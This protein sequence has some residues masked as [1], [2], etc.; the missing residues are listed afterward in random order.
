[1]LATST[2]YPGLTSWLVGDRD[3][4]WACGCSSAA[5][6]R[7]LLG[8]PPPPPPDQDEREQAAARPRRRAAPAADGAGAL[9]GVLEPGVVEPGVL[10]TVVGIEVV[11]SAVAV[12]VVLGVVPVAVEIFV[13]GGPVRESSVKMR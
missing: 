2:E 3:R 10:A 5:E 12:G 9:V 6:A 11:G 1:M 7:R 13:E 4:R 8:I